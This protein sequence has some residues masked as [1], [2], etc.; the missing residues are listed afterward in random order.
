MFGTAF[1]EV[2]KQGAASAVSGRLHPARITSWLR[3]SEIE[4]DGQSWL[5]KI[6]ALPL[7]AVLTLFSIG[8]RN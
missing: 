5:R 4:S 1:G 6:S 7:T 8:R 3:V 2:A